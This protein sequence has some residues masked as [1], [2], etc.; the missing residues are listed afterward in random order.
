MNKKNTSQGV[1]RLTVK[2]RL[3]MIAII[4]LVA[5]SL[6]YSQPVNWLIQQ[7]NSYLHTNF[8]LV[9]KPFI[10]GLD[11]Q[12]G[13]RLEYE[14]DV[15]K[16]PDKDKSSAMEGV[17]D[18]IE[19]RVNSMGVSEPVV[20]VTKS[21]SSW[22]VS[23]ELAGVK[24][25]N[26]AIKM[27]GETPILEFKTQNTEP[28]RELTVEEKKKIVDSKL[29]AVKQSTSFIKELDGKIDDFADLAKKEEEKDSSLFHYQ[30]LGFIHDKPE[31]AVLF[32]AVKNL[33]LG[34]VTKEPVSV[35]GAELVAKVK[36][37][38]PLD[39]EVKARHILI[40]FKGSAAAS[41]SNTNKRRSF[42]V[43][44]FFKREVK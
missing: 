6:T 17:R 15:S 27:I 18:V 36:D 23:A 11:L 33:K 21:G 5:G 32:E 2:R 8:G 14:A 1:S 43:Y 25:V 10:L 29:Q 28:P 44:H 26:K 31:Y 20:Q 34:E 9:N 3:S 7:S 37:T 16:I 19:R 13:T 38:K 22:R 12:G 40:T 30:D 41:S 24:D 42:E 4:F 39:P 35:Y